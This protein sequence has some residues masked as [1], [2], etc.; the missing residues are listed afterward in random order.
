VTALAARIPYRPRM[1]IGRARAV[2]ILMAPLVL[3]AGIGVLAPV[4]GLSDPNQQ[5]LTHTLQPPALF[6]GNWGHP[7]GTDKLGRDMLAQLAYGAR[8][9]FLIGLVGMFVAVIPGSL[10]GVLAGYRRG[11]VDSVV[12]RLVDA[13]LA[14]PFVL[15]AIAI[16][17]ARGPSLTILFVVIAIT[18][19]AHVARIVRA[20]TLS[21]RERRFVMA[22]RAAGAS[23]TRI[24]LRHVLPNL[25]GTIVVLA[26]LQIGSAILIESALSYLGLGVVP[27]QISWGEILA[28]GKDVVQQA[29]WVATLPGI[30]ITIVVLLVNLLGDALLTYYDPKKRRYS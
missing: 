22:L 6:G 21:L 5:D 10:L 8:L 14:L 30:L 18:G 4:L 26:T 7:L 24:I 27:P 13:Q 15:V 9:T 23:N 16:I 12:S 3:L 28:N 11:F 25:S 2:L 29:W 20:E 1:R 19:W 17:T